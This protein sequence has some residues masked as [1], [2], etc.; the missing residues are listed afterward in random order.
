[1]SQ[2]NSM[3]VTNCTAGSLADVNSKNQIRKM[4]QLHCAANGGA[5]GTTNDQTS[6]FAKKNWF[7]SA[8]VVSYRDASSR[9]SHVV[10]LNLSFTSADLAILDDDAAAPTGINEC[11]H[12]LLMPR[13]RSSASYSVSR[14][15]HHALLRP[16]TNDFA[17]ATPLQVQPI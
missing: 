15:F 3:R 17:L 1:M 4:R 12:H 7:L 6:W 16:R 5:N 10:S 13:P 2:I 14:N 8:H 11:D 9:K